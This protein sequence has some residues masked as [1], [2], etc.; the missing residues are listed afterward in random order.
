[1]DERRRRRR[2]EQERKD[3]TFIN[4]RHSRNGLRNVVT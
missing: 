3:N 2:E 4:S 1:L